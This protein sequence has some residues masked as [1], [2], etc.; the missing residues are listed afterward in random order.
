ME[1]FCA[2]NR[3]ISLPHGA[4]G[5]SHASAGGEMERVRS[6]HSEKIC[7]NSRD[8]RKGHQSLPNQTHMAAVGQ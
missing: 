8:P 1:N 2:S 4:H 6:T 5:P 7:Y 3:E